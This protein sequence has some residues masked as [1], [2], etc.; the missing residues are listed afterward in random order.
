MTSKF[1]NRRDAS[2]NIISQFFSWGQINASTDY[3]YTLDRL[4]SVRELTNSS[5]ALQAVYAYD[6]YGRVSRVLETVPSDFGFAGYYLH[7]RSGL[8]L[9]LRREYSSA[10]GR[11]F[12]RDPANN[13]ETNQGVNLYAYVQNSLMDLI[14]PLGMAY[15][16]DRGLAGLCHAWIPGLSQN[17]WLARHNIQ[18]SHADIIFE[19]GQSPPSLGYF[20]KDKNGPAGIHED[21]D[22][23]K[24]HPRPGHYDDCLMRQA[25][26]RLPSVREVLRS[27]AQL[28]GLDHG[29]N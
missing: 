8:N 19:D 11:W 16:G 10:L 13:S 5:S 18:L 4:G 24:I 25:A 14:D 21:F 7:A 28:P 17:Q 6:P 27:R 15:I 12:S 29:C 1:T 3:F 9:T 20:P 26:R 2:S 23:S 22:H